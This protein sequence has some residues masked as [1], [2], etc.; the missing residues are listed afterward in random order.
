MATRRGRSTVSSENDNQ[1]DGA[2][3]ILRA[4]EEVI[5]ESRE[6]HKGAQRKARVQVMER[7]SI[8]LQVGELDVEDRH[9]RTIGP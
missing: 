4:I 6:G 9:K 8:G 7:G 3:V 1:Q 2:Q 5:R